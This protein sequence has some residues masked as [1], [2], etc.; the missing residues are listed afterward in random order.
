LH[1]GIRGGV[2][3]FWPIRKGSTSLTAS[4]SSPA[5]PR[6]CIFLANLIVQ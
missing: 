6:R 1:V 2:K 4:I 5:I 3:W